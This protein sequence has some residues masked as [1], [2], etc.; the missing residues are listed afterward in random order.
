MIECSPE[1]KSDFIREVDLME[2]MRSPFIVSFLGAVVTP[3]RMCLVTEFAS[4]LEKKKEAK[5]N[6]K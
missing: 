4:N 2:R 3:K 1:V 6:G 5:R